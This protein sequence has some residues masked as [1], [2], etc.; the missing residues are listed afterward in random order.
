[1]K[2]SHKLVP[3]PVKKETPDEGF[4]GQFKNLK[5]SDL[6]Q[7]STQG[8][9]SVI[10]NILQGNKKG[11]IYLYNGEITHAVCDNK[12]GIDAFFE[13]MSWKKGDF[14]TV[15]YEPPPIRSITLPW[16]HLLIEAHR[17]M[18]EKSAKKGTKKVEIEFSATNGF[19]TDI[20]ELFQQWG[21]THQD[22]C[23]IGIISKD[24]VKYFYIRDEQLALKKNF[25]L[26]HVF[27]YASNLLCEAYGISICNEVI[28]N[29]NEGAVVILFWGKETPVFV[30]LKG[31]ISQKAVL[32]LEIESLMT[33]ARQQLSRGTDR[34]E[35]E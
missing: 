3:F 8:K 31:D 20:I 10:F 26:L 15:A 16:E 27:P 32:K 11:K 19:P 21:H 17:W 1:M 6:I 22:V 34:F 4:Q 18:D 25:E 28:I 33:E 23:E 30:H 24:K 5:L 7:L 14:E 29:G 35:S 13:I 12:T 2:Q 9:M